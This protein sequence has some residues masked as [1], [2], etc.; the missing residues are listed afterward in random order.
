[1]SILFTFNL[2]MW[3]FQGRPIKH[4][5]VSSWFQAG[6]KVVSKS[7]QDGFRVPVRYK[8]CCAFSFSVSTHCLCKDNENKCRNNSERHL[9]RQSL[10]LTMVS[11]VPDEVI[12]P[13]QDKDPESMEARRETIG[14]PLLR[15]PSCSAPTRIP[16]CP[17]LPPDPK[18]APLSP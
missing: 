12:L 18:L 2:Y 15:I 3:W 17:P 10:C 8:S 11:Q 14:V 5:V 4:M 7:S 6:F 13:T 16:G 9:L 1:M